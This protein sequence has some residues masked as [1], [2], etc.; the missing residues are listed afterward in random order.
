MGIKLVDKVLNLM[1][2]EEDDSAKQV[3]ETS[4]E[5]M[6]EQWNSRKKDKEKAPIFNIHSQKQVHVVVSEPKS[7]DEAQ[8]I[9]DN[10]K[11]RC[12]IIVNLENAD[13]HLAERVVDFV[14]GA[15]YA[16][17]G[18]MQKVGTGIFLFVPNNMDINS[19]LKFTGREK[20]KERLSFPWIA[21]K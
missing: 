15:C 13:A 7:Y 12:P 5:E 16:L 11:N 18:S 6:R 2:F 19:E 9:T 20:D 14:S 3:N 4:N 10:L 21:N 17:N 1:G 8:V